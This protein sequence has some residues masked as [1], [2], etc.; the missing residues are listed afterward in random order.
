MK[1]LKNWKGFLYGIIYGLAARTI[2]ALEEFRYSDAPNGQPILQTYGLMTMSFMFLVPFVIGLLTAYHQDTITSSR[3]IAALTM[4]VFAIFGL[5]GIS[6]LSGKEGIICALMA[7][8]VFLFMA[9]LGGYIGVRI[10]RRN[11]NK[12]YISLFVLLPFL[13]TPLETQL[14]LT[15]KI[16]TEHTAIVINASNKQVWQNITRVKEIKMGEITGHFFNLWVFQ[17]LLKLNL[18]P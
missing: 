7:L 3:K 9:L 13:I 17:D 2:F 1:H 5:F 12:L 11:K 15:D 10:F 6:V 14:G 16:F 4:P 8:P 18:T